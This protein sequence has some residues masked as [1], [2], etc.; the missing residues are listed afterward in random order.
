MT[1]F[2]SSPYAQ[3]TS[4]APL[5]APL[6]TAA[7]AGNTGSKPM[8][9]SSVFWSGCFLR[10]TSLMDLLESCRF[11]LAKTAPSSEIKGI[12]TTTHHRT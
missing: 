12:T 8:R 5:P 1:S 7:V 4:L 3:P 6:K 9:R 2:E 10:I 11:W